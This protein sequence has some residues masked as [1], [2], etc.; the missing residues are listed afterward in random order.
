MFARVEDLVFRPK[1]VVKEL[2]QCVGGNIVP[3]HRFEYQLD[4]A[5]NGGGHGKH[6]SDLLSAFV[7]Y[8]VSP[9]EYYSY[10]SATDKVTMEKVFSR[11][12]GLYEALG[13][14][15]LT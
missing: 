8:G 11:G 15:L 4:S 5:N 13:Y 2:C 7:K 10:F 6:R 9:E 14:R 1:Q 12:E 3:D